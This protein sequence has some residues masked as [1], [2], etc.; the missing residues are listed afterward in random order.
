MSLTRPI[1]VLLAI[2]ALRRSK[3]QRAKIRALITNHYRPQ[4]PGRIPLHTGGGMFGDTLLELLECGF[5]TL[6]DETGRDISVDL[7]SQASPNRKTKP[8]GYDFIRTLRNREA[9]V[10]VALTSRLAQVQAVLG[11]SVSDLIRDNDGHWI[12]VKPVFGPR[13]GRHQGGVFVVMPFSPD[14]QHVYADHI[15]KV[16]EELN[17]RCSR[18]DDFSGSTEIMKDVWDAIAGRDI[19]VA[20]CT[21][22]NP[23][24]FYELG[25]AHT[26]GKPVILIA[27]SKLDIPFD[28]AH[29]RYIK[30]KNDPKGL[31]MLEKRLAAFIREHADVDSSAHS[32]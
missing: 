21:G 27:Q 9:E 4:K 7:M 19:I 25:I 2:D 23:N 8:S 22:Q 10:E 28:V 6:H 13:G 26:L 17:M 29:F 3:G 5:I 31:A 18:A 14:L 15:A 1:L 32:L 24:V 11:L 12:R 20:D 16:C 30:Y